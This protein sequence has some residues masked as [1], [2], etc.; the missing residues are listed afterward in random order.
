M[1]TSYTYNAGQ[2]DIIRAR[3]K[4]GVRYIGAIAGTGGGKTWLGPRW[5]YAEILDNPKDAYLAVSPTYGMLTATVVVKLLEYFSEIGLVED[6][7]YTYHRATSDMYIKLFCGATIYLRSADNPQRFEGIHARAAWLDEGGQVKKLAFETLQ[8]RVG[9]VGGKILVTSTPYALNW[10]YHDFYKRYQNGDGLYYVRQWASIENPTYSVEE[11]E[12]ARRELT[13]ERFAMMMQGGFGKAQGLIYPS[14]DE[15][16]VDP[17]DISALWPRYMS[18][19]F[20][21]NNYTAVLWGAMS[22]DDVLYIYDEHYDRQRLL[23]EHATEIKIHEIGQRVGRRWGDGAAAQS[24]ADLVPLGLRLIPADKDVTSGI[25][26]VNARLRT[27]RLKFVRGACPHLVDEL[28]TYRYK[29][30]TLTE[31]FF[32]EPVKANDHAADA[33]RYLITGVD[34]QKQANI[35]TLD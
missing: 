6:T 15:C 3:Y 10:L 34:P 17:F 22:P 32:E 21:F 30:D 1:T 13:P 31:E 9:L 26:R 16:I 29:Q 25:S 5:L 7:H 35:R 18:M 28:A 20:G 19:D 11:Y 14:F 33:L 23:S 8:R 2:S 24:I 27:G 4:P 12:R